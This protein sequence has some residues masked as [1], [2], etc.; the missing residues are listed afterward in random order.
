M[1]FAIHV[2]SFSDG[3]GVLNGIVSIVLL[4]VLIAL[5][6]L[7]AFVMHKNRKNLT[8]EAMKAKIGSLYLGMH[9]KNLG[10]RLYSSVFL[11]RRLMYAI[12]TVVCIDNPNI[13]IHVFLATN[14]LY[15]VYMGLVSPNDT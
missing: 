7:F 10:Q 4:L 2:V 15:V 9:V 3:T 8:Q 12:L 5:P 6:F 1:V 14:L 13:L 11:A